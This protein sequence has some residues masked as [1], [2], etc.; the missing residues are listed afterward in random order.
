M[1]AIFQKKLKTKTGSKAFP[2]SEKSIFYRHS[3]AEQP[4]KD[5]L[6]YL[7]PFISS[8]VCLSK[9]GTPFIPDPFNLGRATLGSDCK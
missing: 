1:S 3:Q 9:K 4:L 2:R 5:I 8:I 6:N 7:I